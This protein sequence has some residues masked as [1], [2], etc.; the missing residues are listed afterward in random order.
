MNRE[1]PSQEIEIVGGFVG[2][3]QEY[4]FRFFVN[5][6]SPVCTFV[7]KICCIVITN[8]GLQVVSR[9][10][11]HTSVADQRTC[12]QPITPTDSVYDAGRS[13]YTAGEILALFAL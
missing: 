13:G 4:F 11:N 8:H 12:Q 5:F 1:C 7:H 10:W 3:I 2:R 9:E 6:C